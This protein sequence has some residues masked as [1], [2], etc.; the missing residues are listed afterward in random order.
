[1][2]SEYDGAYQTLLLNLQ[3]LTDHC[4]VTTKLLVC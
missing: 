2:K 4:F 1:M 3:A